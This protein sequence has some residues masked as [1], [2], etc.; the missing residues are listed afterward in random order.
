LPSFAELKAAFAADT[1]LAVVLGPLSGGTRLR[2][3]LHGAGAGEVRLFEE[4]TPEAAA[5]PRVL[6]LRV[7]DGDAVRSWFAEVFPDA[8][9]ASALAP[10]DRLIEEAIAARIDSVDDPRLDLVPGYLEIEAEL[11]QIGGRRFFDFARILA[12]ISPRP[13]QIGDEWVQLANRLGGS[14]WSVADLNRVLRDCARAFAVVEDGKGNDTARFSSPFLNRIVASRVKTSTSEHYA[15]FRALREMAV[16]SL[17]RQDAGDDFVA[18]ELPLQASEGD[19]IEEFCDD[20]MALLASDPKTLIRVAETATAITQGSKLVLRAAHRLGRPDTLSQLELAARRGSMLRLADDIAAG[21][22]DRPWRPVWATSQPVNTNRVVF[23]E[24]ANVVCLTAHPVHD[25]IGYA[26]LTDG[27]V[28][29]ISRYDDQRLVWR[30]EPVSEIRAIAGLS[31]GGETFVFTGHSDQGIRAIDPDH[32]RVRWEERSMSGPLSAIAAVQAGRGGLVAAGGVDG[33]LLLLDAETGVPLMERTKLGV[34]I[35]G[36]EILSEI[37]L[38]CLVDGQLAGIDRLTGAL[39]WRAPVPRDPAQPAADQVCNALSARQAG[40]GSGMYAVVG[41]TAGGLYEAEA[42]S[43]RTKPEIRQLEQLGS[44]INALRIS[45]GDEETVIVAALADAS[46]VKWRRSGQ[47]HKYFGHVGSVNAIMVE[48]GGRV[49]TGSGEGTIRTWLPRFVD[50][51]SVTLEWGVRHRGPVTGINIDLASSRGEVTL[52]TGGADGTLRAWSGPS[53]TTGT[54]IAE[55]DSPVRALIWDPTSETVY[56]GHADGVLRTITR[57]STGWE[58]RLVG[59]QHDGVRGLALSPS[60]RLY[61][62]GVDG[63]VT[64]WHRDLSAGGAVTEPVSEFGYVAAIG[65]LNDALAVGGQDG[66]VHLL[67]PVSLKAV[68]SVDLGASITS[69]SGHDGDLFVG[70]A[71]GRI[72]IL[73]NFEHSTP[74]PKRRF[75]EREIH[76][77]EVRGIQAFELGGNVVI[78][79]TGLDRRVVL[80]DLRTEEQ[81]AEVP[82]DG[83][84]LGMHADPPYLAVPTTSGAMVIELSRELPGFLGPRKVARTHTGAP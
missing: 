7:N 24:A 77:G 16:E 73:R 65:W 31:I 80:T 48:P 46:W 60:G 45:D 33:D 62:A 84:G 4:L 11:L 13:V 67:H 44:S 39:L 47:A 69:I 15:L 27:S 26:G 81:L 66:K 40:Q 58:P 75:P 37:V 22:P 12:L 17:H 32:G 63:T 61:S 57:T 53:D 9:I 52:V 71:T 49:I 18:I 3:W 55:H 59:I 20:G 54:R 42:A 10:A 14:S 74:G 2:E 28:W 36:I 72:E 68:K 19:A 79:T 30:Q 50:V 25:E 29:E 35:R 1:P 43:Q 8:G 56:V 21:S 70:L 64:R 6:D 41:T 82:L 51:E 38:V 76:H 78:A 34:E 83:F 5:Y 23:F